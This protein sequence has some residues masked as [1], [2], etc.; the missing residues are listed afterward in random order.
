MAAD[1]LR[2]SKF[3]WSDWQADQALRSCGVAARGLWM[4]MLCIANSGSPRGHVTINGVPVSTKRL[5]VLAGL[6]EKE[7]ASLLQELREAGVFSETPE[8]VI[9]S[10]RMVRDTLVAA[11]GR[12]AVGK[13]WG[14]RDDPTDEPNSDPIR[15]AST[16]EAKRQK[17]EAERSTSPTGD[18][19]PP[20]AETPPL[21]LDEPAA[22][23]PA[24][25]PVPAVWAVEAWNEQLGVTLGRV[26][27]FTEARRSALRARMT[28]HWRPDYRAGWTAFLQRIAASDFL[29]GRSGSGRPFRADFDWVLKPAN[30]VKILEGRYDNDR[31][32]PAPPPPG[33]WREAPGTI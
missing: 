32:R 26:Q 23:K 11:A 8:G 28:Q 22:S 30:A 33:Q 7:C 6:T 9:Y 14:K 16:L 29:T 31:D 19:S 4:D 2:W 15:G 21:L 5:A 27:T 12:E 24:E 18:V 25:P 20:S 10:R 17:L 3:W 1:T 13:R